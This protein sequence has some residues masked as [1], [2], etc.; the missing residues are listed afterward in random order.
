MVHHDQQMEQPSVPRWMRVSTTSGLVGGVLMT[1]TGLALLSVPNEAEFA[2]VDPLGAVAMVLLALALPALYASERHWFGRLATA[3]FGLLSSGWLLAA[4]ALPVAVYGPGVAFLAFLLGLLVAMVGAFA[5][6]VATLRTDATAAPRG[7][8][9]FLVAALPVG[10]PFAVGFTT[11][12]MGQGADPW[13]GPLLCYGLAWV[14]FGRYLRER[15]SGA[16]AAGA[17]A[18]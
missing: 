13:A 10:L 18:R 5:F 1:I 2:V 15:G 3:G 14:V 6:G 4:V 16:L 12:V 7:A 8:A 11:Y 17:V 9:W